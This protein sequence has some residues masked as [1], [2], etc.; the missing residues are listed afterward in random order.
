MIWIAWMNESGWSNH[1]YIF[2]E[3]AMKKG[4]LNVYLF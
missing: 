4:I 2:G 1:V 3:E